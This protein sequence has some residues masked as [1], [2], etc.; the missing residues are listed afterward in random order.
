MKERAFLR[1]GLRSGWTIA[2]VGA[3]AL[4]GKLL[5]A[6][7]TYGT[8]DVY[9][10]DQFSVWSR[11]LGV[12]LYHLDPLFNHPPSMIHVLH[13][14]SWLAG[15]TGLPFA[16]WLRVPAITADAA[17]LWLVWKLLGERV[18]EQSIFWALV[19]LAA[20]PT[21]IL[22]SGFHGNTDSVV[23]FFVLLS[24]YLVEKDSSPWAAGAALG[25]AHCVKVYPLIAAPA[26]LLNLP[27]WNRRI[28]FCAAAA[29][30]VL[31][32]W[33]PF[34]YQDPRVVLG[35]VFGYR[36]SYGMWGLSYIA[37]NLT[38]MFPRLMPLNAAFEH[39][40]AYLSLGLVCAVSWRMSRSEPKPQLFSQIGL[41][42]I[43]FLSV[44]SGFGVQYLAWLAPWV[45]EQGWLAAA[46][47]YSTSGVFL[48]LVYNLWA[49][50]FP[51]YLADSYDIGTF[52]GYYD[53]S[54]LLCW[55]SL[56]MVLWLAWK[57]LLPMPPAP[58]VAWRWIAAVA[59]AVL[60]FA[61]F[62]VI[63]PAQLPTPQP[64]GGKYEDAVRSINAR[65]YL[66]LAAELSDLRRYQ[67][68]IQAAREAI[69]LTPESA[70]EANEIIAADETAL[71]MRQR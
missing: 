51:W 28:K 22:V 17:N 63:V 2:G 4:L 36:S 7:K 10:Y 66:D 34:I 23:M 9:S 58:L 50:G 11:Y 46:L 1:P 20:T 27:S 5:L 52:V 59:A 40:G 69:A 68:S 64:A 24:V 14:M 38:G 3:V 25:L 56:L 21:L 30:V 26:I 43:L 55:I 67:D 70:D 65:S 12:S 37:D 54:Q 49:Q 18:R 19:L 15:V 61:V 31:I 45:V 47:F 13:G 29:A 32:T 6:L 16:F 8:N 48:F 57:K 62:I 33:A 44:S 35:Q 42:F 71:G 39:A 53:Y 60:I 41:V